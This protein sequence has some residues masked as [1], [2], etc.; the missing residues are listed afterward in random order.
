MEQ[1]HGEALD[2]QPLA[3]D[4]VKGDAARRG[5]GL[6]EGGETAFVQCVQSGA[7]LLQRGP[8]GADPRRHYCSSALS[9]P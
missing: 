7:D 8:V 2:R 1:A 4:A 6:D 5:D 3:A 9:P